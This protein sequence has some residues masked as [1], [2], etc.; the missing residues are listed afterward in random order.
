MGLVR[1]HFYDC[2]LLNVRMWTWD[3]KLVH[4]SELM[5]CT[6]YYSKVT[7]KE[8]GVAAVKEGGGL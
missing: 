7:M 2:A 3:L 5:T 1:A 4:G 8:G 6:G